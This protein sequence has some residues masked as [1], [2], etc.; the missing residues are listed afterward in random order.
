MSSSSSIEALSVEKALSDA[1]SSFSSSDGRGEILKSSTL[2][3]LLGPPVFDRSA[4]IFHRNRHMRTLSM[5]HFTAAFSTEVRLRHCFFSSVILEHYAK[6]RCRPSQIANDFRDVD[7]DSDEIDTSAPIVIGGF[8]LEER[9]PFDVQ[10]RPQTA[11]LFVDA[12]LG[13]PTDGKGKRSHDPPRQLPAIAFLW[14][15]YHGWIS[16]RSGMT[17]N[18][19]RFA[20]EV[21]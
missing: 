7:D 14:R 21:E 3:L 15:S 10:R 16:L 4:P 11:P 18:R 5:C 2:S 17:V 9:R 12:S 1:V 6:N 19:R 8:F 13:W 20:G